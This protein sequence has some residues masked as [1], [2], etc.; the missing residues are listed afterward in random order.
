[1]IEASSVRSEL[2]LGEQGV[3][4][5]LKQVVHLSLISLPLRRHVDDLIRRILGVAEEHEEQAEQQREAHHFAPLRALLR[6]EVVIGVCAIH[7]CRA[8][9]DR[10]QKSGVS[11]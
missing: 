4:Y 5:L 8:E 2:R 1:L 10:Q 6:D 7:E 3:Y 9:E 11:L